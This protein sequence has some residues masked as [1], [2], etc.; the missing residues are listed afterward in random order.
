[1]KQLH[2]LLQEIGPALLDMAG[3]RGRRWRRVG[4]RL[5]RLDVDIDTILLRHQAKTLAAA[6]YYNIRWMIN[7]SLFLL[8]AVILASLVIFRF[9]YLW[10]T[11]IGVLIGMGP[12]VIIE[13]WRMNPRVLKE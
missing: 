1:M 13:I 3:A 10:L 7:A 2:R 11:W 9:G 6:K 5:R 8:V 4:C 12:H